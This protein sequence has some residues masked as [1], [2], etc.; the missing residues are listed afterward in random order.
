[1]SKF[2]NPLASSLGDV[3]FSRLS[4]DEIKRVSVKRIHVTPTF[5]SLGGPA[6]G[7]LY[8]PALGAVRALDTT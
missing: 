1:M 5:D 4:A 8:D 6:P 7:G 3:E 2:P